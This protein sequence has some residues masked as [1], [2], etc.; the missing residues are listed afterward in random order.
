MIRPPWLPLLLL[1]CLACDRETATPEDTNVAATN[2]TPQQVCERAS[3]RVVELGELDAQAAVQDAPDDQKSM[4][5]AFGQEITNAIA[6][7]FVEVCLELGPSEFQCMTTI[8]GYADA[9]IP[10]R[11]GE[12]ECR[13]KDPSACAQWDTDIETA[14][15]NYGSCVQTLEQVITHA[16]ARGQPEPKSGVVGVM[17]QPDAEPP[18][19]AP[20]GQTVR[21]VE[22][23]Y[24]DAKVDGA[25][26]GDLVSRIVRAHRP[27]LR[28][29][30]DAGLID[31]PSLAG[32]ITIEFTIGST[33]YVSKAEAVDADSF[34]DPRVANCMAKAVKEWR[35]PKPRGGG[36]VQVSYPFTLSPAR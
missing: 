8:D 13:A 24:H 16:W 7:K 22:L 23:E 4:A 32:R 25:L 15:A 14:R 31:N 12:L 2:P 5:L 26:D 29:C 1:G 6:S 18:P 33:G 35:F 10:A 9:V 21:E 11:R 3:A 36:E 30:Y 27:E 17:V 34:T 28:S 20:S 19:E